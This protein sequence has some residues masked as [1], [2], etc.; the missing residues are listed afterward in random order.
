MFPKRSWFT[1][2]AAIRRVRQAPVVELAQGLVVH[3]PARG[4]V[5]A[6]RRIEDLDE[7]LARARHLAARPQRI[8][9]PH[10]VVPQHVVPGVQAALVARDAA[11]AHRRRG[12]QTDRRPRQQHPVEQRGQAVVAQHRGARHLAQ[13][14]WREDAAQRPTGSTLAQGRRPKATGDYKAWVPGGS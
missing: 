8:A 14:T 10:V 2:A 7:A 12:A 4:A 3:L 9:S 13:K 6:R 5:R 11:A 1:P